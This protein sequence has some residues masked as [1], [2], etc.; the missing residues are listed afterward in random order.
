M[1]EVGKLKKGSF[2][3]R[4]SGGEQGEGVDA[5]GNGRKEGRV[6]KKKEGRRKKKDEGGMKERKEDG[7]REEKEKGETNAERTAA[8]APC[9]MKRRAKTKGRERQ[10]ERQHTHLV[11]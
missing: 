11:A 1:R 10:R 5:S 2:W 7:E 9:C 8:R 4:G 3:E 6:K